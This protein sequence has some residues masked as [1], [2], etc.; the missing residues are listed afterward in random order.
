MALGHWAFPLSMQWCGAQLAD[1]AVAK[2]TLSHSR[3]I[4]IFRPKQS[5]TGAQVCALWR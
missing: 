3:C 5:G 2:V 4:F 1:E